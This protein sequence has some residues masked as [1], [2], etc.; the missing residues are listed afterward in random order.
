MLG[1]PQKGLW[2]AWTLLQV[3]CSPQ[4]FL[5]AITAAGAAYQVTW[6]P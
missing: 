2:T 6:S 4:G 1:A 3:A 5:V